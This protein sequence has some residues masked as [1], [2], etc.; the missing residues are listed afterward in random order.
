VEC[1][2]ALSEIRPFS[3]SYKFTCMT[4]SVN[5]SNPKRD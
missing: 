5:K 3:T 1:P 2:E 4:I